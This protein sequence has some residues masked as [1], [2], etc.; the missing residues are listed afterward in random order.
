MLLPLQLLHALPALAGGAEPRRAGASCSFPDARP[1]AHNATAPFPPLDRPLTCAP[2]SADAGSAGGRFTL[3]GAAAGVPAQTYVDA[4][5]T[6]YDNAPE[7]SF[8]NASRPVRAALLSPGAGITNASA[9]GHPVDHAKLLAALRLVKASGAD[10]VLMTEEVFGNSQLGEV[11]AKAPL[12][13]GFPYDGPGEDVL[14]GPHISA[15]RAAAKQLAIYVVVPFRMQL[16]AG[17]SYNGAVIVGRDGELMLST[18]GVPYYQKTFPCLGYPMG[19]VSASA[20]G[21]YAA[22]GGIDHGGETPLI[23]GQQGVQAWDLPGI[24]RVAIIIC[25]DVRAS[26]E[27][28][29]DGHHHSHSHSHAAVIR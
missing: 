14:D 22:Y 2:G 17:E 27:H 11:G 26:S 8:V 19:K 13:G 18:A 15:V 25:F 1:W 28:N 16:A 5:A 4:R 20:P 21:G 24:G 7:A 29:T 23:P 9:P 10:I 12:N 6:V 3:P